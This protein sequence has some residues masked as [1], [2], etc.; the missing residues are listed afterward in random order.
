MNRISN[1]LPTDFA[2]LQNLI[3]RDPESYYDEVGNR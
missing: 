2:S 3:K 1:K